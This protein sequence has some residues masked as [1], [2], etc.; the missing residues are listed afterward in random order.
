M[1][2]FVP[3]KQFRNYILFRLHLNWIF[4]KGSSWLKTGNTGEYYLSIIFPQAG[5][6]VLLN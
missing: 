5:L 1:F 6:N 4:R 2:L 3:Q